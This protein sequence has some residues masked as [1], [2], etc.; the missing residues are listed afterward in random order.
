[1]RYCIDYP[2]IARDMGDKG[3]IEEIECEV[4]VTNAHEF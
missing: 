2:A 3:E 4:V 1:L